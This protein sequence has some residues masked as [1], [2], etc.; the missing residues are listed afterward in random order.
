MALFFLLFSGVFFVPLVL[1]ILAISRANRAMREVQELRASRGNAA[2]EKRSEETTA[3][4]DVSARCPTSSVAIAEAARA[5]PA[6]KPPLPTSHT[7]PPIPAKPTADVELALGGRVA[8]YIGAVAVV[9]AVAFFVGYAIQMGLIGPSVR[10]VLSGC[11][12]L[13]LL[14]AG[15]VFRRQA[16]PHAALAEALTGAGSGLLFF[17]VF[18]AHRQY[19]L[20]GSSLAL[21]GLSIAAAVVLLIARRADSQATAIIGTLGAYLTP[22]LVEPLEHTGGF[23]LVYVVFVNLTVLLLYRVRTWPALPN[24]AVVCAVLHML[25]SFEPHSMRPWKAA[26]LL[27]AVYAGLIGLNGIAARRTRS[28]DARTLDVMRLCALA[29]VFGTRLAQSFAHGD[30]WTAAGFPLALAAIAHALI[31]ARFARRVQAAGESA[32]CAHFA[33]LFITAAIWVRFDGLAVPALW[34][35]EG[36]VLAA[37]SFVRSRPSLLA[38]ALLL[39]LV[40]P[41]FAFTEAAE[42]SAEVPLLFNA[43]Y[44]MSLALALLLAVFSRFW[45]ISPNPPVNAT[46][47]RWM[48]TSIVIGITAF[49][50]MRSQKDW[51]QTAASVWLGLSAFSVTGLGLWTRR[52]GVRLYGLTLFGVTVVKV[53]LVDLAGLRG[54]ERAGAFLTTGLLLLALSYLYQ[55][56]AAS[57]SQRPP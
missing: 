45:G 21:A 55:R 6:S 34:G 56:L 47:V 53:F 26:L 3:S 23:P 19:D 15:Q 57:I 13:T 29:A 30:D 17:T 46:L 43:S 22:W 32:A 52:R 27:T 11:A 31:A 1:S 38:H 35:V 10:V 24:L 42:A 9:I 36:T 50:F 33:A 54:L 2:P 20:I 39:G 16:V 5:R 48:A 7:P 51:A 44:G 25:I 4:V 14:V 12:A 40:A 18:A 41:I 49:E 8:S 28:G 37:L